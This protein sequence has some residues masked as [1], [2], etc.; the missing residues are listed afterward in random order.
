VRVAQLLSRADSGQ[1]VGTAG[2]GSTVQFLRV[3]SSCCCRPAALTPALVVLTEMSAHMSVAVEAGLQILRQGATCS[4]RVR[5]VRL[6][7]S[8]R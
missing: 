1:C 5:R 6:K 7:S 8:S 3:S 2:S 4:R